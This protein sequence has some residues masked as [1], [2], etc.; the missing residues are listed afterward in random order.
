MQLYG[1]ISDPF[2]RHQPIRARKAVQKGGPTAF[3]DVLKSDLYSDLSS[4]SIVG[5]AL[6]FPGTLTQV[7]RFPTLIRGGMSLRTAYSVY[8]GHLTP[9]PGLGVILAGE[10]YS[11]FKSR[12]Q[13]EKSRALARP[14]KPKTLRGNSKPS[15]P[16]RSGQ[17]SKPFWANGKPKC[18]K[19]FRYDFKRKL[20]VKIK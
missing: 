13:D 14:V 3:G 15:R 16:T 17:T 1:K 10:L 8:G 6:L 18:K 9:F 20:C 7:A 2:D 11:R 4:I 12:S 19:G 5:S